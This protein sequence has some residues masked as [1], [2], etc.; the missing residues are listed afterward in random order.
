VHKEPNDAP[1][2]KA[3]FGLVDD[4]MVDQ[5]SEREALAEALLELVNKEPQL[6]KKLHSKTASLKNRKR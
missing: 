6:L 3:A 1:S 4:A 5:H 2:I